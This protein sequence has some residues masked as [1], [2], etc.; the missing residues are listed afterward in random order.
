THSINLAKNNPNYNSNN[1]HEKNNAPNLKRKVSSEIISLLEDSDEDTPFI[2]LRNIPTSSK[3]LRIVNAKKK[4]KSCNPDSSPL[5]SDHN[6]SSLNNMH[7][8]TLKNHITSAINSN[9]YKNVSNNSNNS[10]SRYFTSS[11]L[12]SSDSIFATDHIP[13]NELLNYNKSKSLPKVHFKNKNSSLTSKIPSDVS[14]KKYSHLSDSSSRFDFDID[15]YLSTNQLFKS[16]ATDLGPKMSPQNLSF[17]TFDHTN[18]VKVYHKYPQSKFLSSE[19][20]NSSSNSELFPNSNTHNTLLFSETNAQNFS[21]DYPLNKF[22]DPLVYSSD[23]DLEYSNIR[24]PTNNHIKPPNS[25]PKTHFGSIKLSGNP[26][27]FSK[28]S[29]TS[30]NDT[31]L[32]VISD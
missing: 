29:V 8:P 28:D 19:I 12:H 31:E 10:N 9:N 13:H 32:I 17:E 21:E 2:S 22:T 6:K 26:R 3:S 4:V 5:S 11:K 30:P 1:H 7:I 25:H 20:S 14:T 23:S 24:Q 27:Q 16:K 18:P 15:D